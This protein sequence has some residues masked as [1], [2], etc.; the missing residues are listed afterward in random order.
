MKSGARES[1]KVVRRSLEVCQELDIQPYVLKFWEGEFPQLGRRVGPKR[2]YGP[3]EFALAV[4]IKRLLQEDGI[5]LAEARDALSSFAGD[6]AAAG[7]PLDEAEPLA[8]CQIPVVAHEAIATEGQPADG[9]DA[10]STIATLT[11]E[12]DAAEGREARARRE[13]EEL[14]GALAGLR[15]QLHAAQAESATIARQ[16]DDATA[17]FDQQGTELAEAQSELE[18][19]RAEVDGLHRH[20]GELQA[21]IDRGQEEQRQQ[22]M[23]KTKLV[24]TTRQLQKQ[25]EGEIRTRDD[26]QARAAKLV[27]MQKRVES[28][29]RE[30]AAERQ[31]IGETQQERRALQE[32]LT[33]QQEQFAQQRSLLLRELGD[34]VGEVKQLSGELA[35]LMVG[36]GG[37]PRATAEPTGP[38][39]PKPPTAGSTLFEG[40]GPPAPR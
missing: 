16:R 22:G 12:R 5:T 15:D 9:Q 29:E 10:A 26:A 13:I 31:R 18:R 7:L 34:A 17:L 21:S 2:L 11:Q 8:L 27:E 28:L 35:T 1:D 6:S 40:G 30:L 33:R 3:D 32:Q 36:L 4:E 38:A 14:R 23:E 19:A 25:L 20:V 24:E 39:A 37:D